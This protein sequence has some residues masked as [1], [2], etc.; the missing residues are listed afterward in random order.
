MKI[1]FIDQKEKLFKHLEQLKSSAVM[2]YEKK[3]L[4]EKITS[5]EIERNFDE[6]N[7]EVLFSYKIFPKNIMVYSTQWEEEKRVMKIGDTI[8][9][10]AYLPPIMKFS[11]K[12]IFGVRI[13][14]VIDEPDRKGFSYETLDGHVEKGVSTFTIE[15]NNNISIF[16]IHTFSIPGNILTKL[17]GP[18][19]SVPY[20]TFCTKMGLKNV[21]NQIEKE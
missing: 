21:K 18:L 8:V 3:R 13:N 15:R 5:I 4:K 9:Q 7:F 12:V 16:K 6:L 11:Q 2:N 1:F 20:Q 10:Q 19:F 17:I 14:E